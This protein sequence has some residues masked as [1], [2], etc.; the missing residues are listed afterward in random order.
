MSFDDG[1]PSLTPR[2]GTHTRSDPRRPE[3]APL[4]DFARY[5]K[6][7][8]YSLNPS[9]DRPMKA[10]ETS[11]IGTTFSWPKCPNH[12]ISWTRP[13]VPLIANDTPLRGECFDSSPAVYHGTPRSVVRVAEQNHS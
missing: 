11:F 13:V 9:S 3:S 1:L 10:S 2:S 5:A 4:N 12:G 6:Y 7:C 8:E